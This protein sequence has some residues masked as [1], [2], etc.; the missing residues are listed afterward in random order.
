M[1]LDAVV[2]SGSGATQALLNMGVNSKKIF[3]GFNVVDHAYWNKQ[4]NDLRIQ[5]TREVGHSYL[6]VG[7]LI[8]R[9]GITDLIRA[10][11]KCFQQNDSL[12]IVGKGNLHFELQ[13]LIN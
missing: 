13:A 1:N 7:R 4:A 10:F 8:E 11:T 12:R 6:Y 5:P 2:S 9:K 3:Q